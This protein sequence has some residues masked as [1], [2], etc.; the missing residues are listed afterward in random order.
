[1]DGE[2]KPADT[3]DRPLYQRFWLISPEAGPQARLTASALCA[4]FSIVGWVLL[5]DATPLA[6]ALCISVSYIC[7][8]A[9][10]TFAAVENLRRRRPDINFL[11]VLVAVVSALLGYW[12]EGAILLLL[13]SLSDGLERYAIERTRRGISALMELRPD[14]ACLVRDGDEREVGVDKLTLGD[15]DRFTFLNNRAQP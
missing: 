6:A 14:T 5:R 1:M 11:M 8:G 10:A 9:R 7:G 4:V 13:F 3:T 12:E 15:R 2:S